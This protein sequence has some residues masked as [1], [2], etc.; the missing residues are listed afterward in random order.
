MSDCFLSIVFPAHNE[1]KRLPRTLEQTAAFL[2][3]QPYSAEIIVVENGS[4]DRTL[5]VAE[6]HAAR[7]PMLRV[8][9]EEQRGKGRA[10]RRGMLAARGEYRFFCDVDLSMPITEINRFFPPQLEGAEI[11]IA[12][13]EAPGSVRYNE[14]AYRHTTG[15]VFN[16]MVKT[17][18]LPGIEDSQC[19]FKCFSAPAAEA[20]FPLQTI[21]GWSFDVELLYAARRRGLRIVELDIPWYFNPDSKVHVLRDSWRMFWD[22]LSIRWNGLRGRYQP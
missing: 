6:E 18:A 17:L 19:G 8:I 3:A 20:L 22:L 21:M 4:T 2:Q 5:A 14:P 16:W 15:R 9:H 12:S 13:R 1:E 11:V 10:V 7:L